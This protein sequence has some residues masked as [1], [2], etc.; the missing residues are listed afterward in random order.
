MAQHHII[1]IPISD[2]TFIKYIYIKLKKRLVKP[3]WLKI[4]TARVFE[5]STTIN[6]T[7]DTDGTV[8]SV[9]KTL[10]AMT[11]SFVYVAI[12]VENKK[13]I[14]ESFQPHA[15]LVPSYGGNANSLALSTKNMNLENKP[16]ERTL[17]M[18]FP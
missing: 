12:I 14:S 10:H 15:S 2:W 17:S 7:D 18:A 6:K 9:G 16:K 1:L 5:F 8:F 11:I 4:F 13:S 3:K